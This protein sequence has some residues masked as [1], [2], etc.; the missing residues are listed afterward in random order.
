MGLSA[1]QGQQPVEMSACYW[2]QANKPVL[3]C[4]ADQELVVAGKLQIVVECSP[5]SSVP[6]WGAAAAGPERG[7]GAAAGGGVGAVPSADE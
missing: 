2:R 5:D 4:T 7:A 3:A 1:A 6:P